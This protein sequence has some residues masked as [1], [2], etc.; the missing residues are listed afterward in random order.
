M[1]AAQQGHIEIVT[2]LSSRGGDV[3]AR[4]IDGQNALIASSGMGF[5]DIVQILVERSKTLIWVV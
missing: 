4:S 1:I 5:L 2:L 3:E